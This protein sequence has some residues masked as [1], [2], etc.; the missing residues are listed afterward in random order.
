M[1]A[2]D[3]PED[4]RSRLA[5]IAALMKEKTGEPASFGDVIGHLLEDHAA[6]RCWRQ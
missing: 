2:I 1:T 6:W 5:E 4:T 3:I